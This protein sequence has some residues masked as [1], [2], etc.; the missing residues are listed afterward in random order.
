M[1]KQ[2]LNDNIVKQ[3]WKI[4]EYVYIEVVIIV[5]K[6]VLNDKHLGPCHN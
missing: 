6:Y 1:Y 3:S 5:D 4:I 2:I